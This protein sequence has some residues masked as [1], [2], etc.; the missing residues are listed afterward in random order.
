MP[1]AMGSPRF[2]WPAAPGCRRSTGCF[3]F[4]GLA[5]LDVDLDGVRL[6]ASA[7]DVPTRAAGHATTRLHVRRQVRACTSSRSQSTGKVRHER[8]LW[9]FANS[10]ARLTFAAARAWR[11][12]GGEHRRAL[13]RASDSPHSPPGTAA[14]ASRR[15]LLRLAAPAG[16]GEITRCPQLARQPALPLR[17]RRDITLLTLPDGRATTVPLLPIM[18]D[19]QRLGLRNDPPQLG[20]H[21]DE[22]LASL[23]YSAA[24]IAALRKAGVIGA[25]P[26]NTAK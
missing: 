26:K 10:A 8:Q 17:Y 12:A 15:I 23:G 9:R 22:V 2:C 3:S 5:P 18:L 11:A 6:N 24:D 4:T 20:E 7:G 13:A 25:A 16:T 14:D 19:S 21:N 1:P